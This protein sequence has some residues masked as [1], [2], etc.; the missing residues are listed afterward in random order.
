MGQLPKV[1]ASRLEIK[2][3]RLARK[4]KF[5]T[6]RD[7]SFW[8]CEELMHKGALDKFIPKEGRGAGWPHYQITYQGLKLLKYLDV[9]PR[10]GYQS[11]Y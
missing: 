3:L 10:H 7:F 5:L 8:E 2:M 11:P 9:N 6:I 4:K 1:Q